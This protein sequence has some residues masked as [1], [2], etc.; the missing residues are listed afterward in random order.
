MGSRVLNYLHKLW[1]L[2]QISFWPAWSFLTAAAVICTAWLFRRPAGWA[3]RE[4]SAP[5]ETQ[6]DWSRKTIVS[7]TVLALFLGGYIAM[8]LVW[9]DFALYD[10]SQ[11]T[12]YSLRGIDFPA[13][14][15]PQDGRFFPLGLQEFNLIGHFTKTVAGYHAFP[16]LEILVLTSVLLLLDDQ[17]SIAG[18]VVLAMSVLISP[19]AVVSF[20]GLIYPE[21]N[22]LVLLACLTLFVRLFEQTRSPGWAVA[23]VVAAQFML[24]L[25]EPVFLLLLGFAGARLILRA[26]SSNRS[27]NWLRDEASR[28]DLFIAVLSVMFLAFYA[29]EML[30]HPSAQY[31]VDRRLSPVDAVRFYLN[32]DPLAWVFAAGALAR[33]CRIICG[34]A[35]PLLLWDGLACGGLVYFGAY[36]GMR[37]V[38]SYFL[39]PVD[40]IAALYLGHL[41]YS[42]WVEM[43]LGVRAVAAALVIVVVCQNV[44]ISAFRVLERKHLVRQRS[45][46]GRMIFETYQ[47]DQ[48]LV[49][50]LYFPLTSAYMMAEFSAYL[51]YLGVPVEEIGDASVGGAPVEI[52]GAK[53]ATDGRCVAWRSFVCHAG[54]AD[55]GSTV[56]VLPDDPVLPGETALYRETEEKLESYDSRVRPPA[57]LVWALRS[58]QIPAARFHELIIFSVTLPTAWEQKR[59]AQSGHRSNE[60]F[61]K[62]ARATNMASL[63][64]VD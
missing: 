42:S 29:V 39:A 57:W 59:E 11:F 53:V 54:G 60:A 55:A 10:D 51:S 52:F 26:R 63:A 18:R 49:R 47:R 2:R 38:S 14:V 64:A 7:L 56:V 21:R 58:V 16:I 28:L 22:I 25:K 44:Q 48:A 4:K 50:K 43:G 34:K 8:T 46:I 40:L 41:L 61:P 30:P 32:A 36:L 1:A 45:A 6:F 5:R 13:P 23:A 12:L 27:F 15:S 20:M 31:L 17:L 19:S 9:E 3:V 33:M 24:Y 62:S 37:I 35:K